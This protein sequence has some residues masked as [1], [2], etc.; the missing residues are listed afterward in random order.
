MHNVFA[1]IIAALLWLEQRLAPIAKHPLGR[2][3]LVLFFVAIGFAPAHAARAAE[4]PGLVETALLFI[5]NIALT[6]AVVLSKLV[7]VIIQVLIPVMLYNKFS[8]SPVV[9]SGWAIVRDTV[10]MFFV[11]V[12]IAIAFGTIFGNSRF[13]WQQQMTRLMIFAIVINFSK[14]LCGLMI[15]IG[16]VIMLT[17]ANAIREIAAGN[18]VKMLG[19]GDVYSLSTD[20]KI[21]QS[22][23]TDSNATG[24]KAFDWFASALMSVFMMFIVLTTMIMLLAILMYRVVMLWIL[25]VIS[26]LAWFVGGAG[27]LIKSGAYA[28]WWKKFICLVAIGPVLTFFLWLT[29]VVAG[30][31]NIS[32]SAGFVAAGSKDTAGGFLTQIFEVKRLISFVI[33][34][35]MLYAGFDAA[36]S[37]CSGAG[38]GMIS[39]QMKGGPGA[40]GGVRA[41]KAVAGLGARVGAKGARV[42]ATYGKKGAGYVFEKSGA[43]DKFT[44]LKENRNQR[45]INDPRASEKQRMAAMSR[46]TEIGAGRAAKVAATGEKYKG[47]SDENKN[48]LLRRKFELPQN[49]EGLKERQALLADAMGDP[50]RMAALRASGI[51]PDM[52]KGDLKEIEAQTK[53]DKGMKAK[54]DAFKKSN[55]DVTGSWGDIKDAKDAAGLSAFALATAKEAKDKD[56]KDDK[57]SMSSGIK[58]SKKEGGGEY[59]VAEALAARKM[60]TKDQQDAYINGRGAI[61]DGMKPEELDRLPAHALAGD[62]TEGIITKNPAIADQMLANKDARVQAALQKRLNE[63]GGDKAR[64]A[65]LAGAG[66]KDGKIEDSKAFIESLQGNPAMLSYL[67]PDEFDGLGDEQMIALGSAFSANPKMLTGAIANIKRNPDAEVNKSVRSRI[68]SI[69]AK[70]PTEETKEAVDMFQA[71]MKTV[72]E[73]TRMQKMG[74]AIKSAPQTA[75]KSMNASVD[76]TFIDS[77]I[78]SGWDSEEY[79]EGYDAGDDSLAAGRRA[80]DED[81]ARADFKQRVESIAASESLSKVL[82]DKIASMEEELSHPP[83]QTTKVDDS[84]NVSFIDRELTREE[85]RAKMRIENKLSKA[86]NLKEKVENLKAGEVA[87]AEQKTLNREANN[88]LDDLLGTQKQSAEDEFFNGKK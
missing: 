76:D 32:D 16:Q 44:K 80:L 25:I 41:A 63:A 61:Y 28:D 6:V 56:P 3:G 13:K 62:L 35:A 15:D 54:M 19:M 77:A 45:I 38:L 34:I 5:A 88:A 33:A 31:G 52:M 86:K 84:G 36:N 55:A 57:L 51:K 24:A 47:L 79:T 67:S 42:G 27:D 65:L 85:D 73:G 22:A 12:L 10:N 1:R 21:F 8:E 59:S 81:Q 64:N 78:K 83:P 68:E 82:D 58:K 9:I 7:I 69:L 37:T 75:K 23:A 17:F 50:K 72:D 66:M 43:E 18:F 39:D 46:S 30:A 71:Q 11:I 29:L 14:T 4:G 60:G 87:A 53:G 70:N 40:S 20:N 26:P 2:V 49:K 48:D 74:R